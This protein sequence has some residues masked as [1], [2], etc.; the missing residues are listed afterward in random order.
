MRREE[1]PPE[2]LRAYLG[3]RGLGVRLLRG[4]HTLSPF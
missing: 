4:R 2:F 3:G 1:I